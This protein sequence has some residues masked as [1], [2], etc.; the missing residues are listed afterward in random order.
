MTMRHLT[1]S[2]LLLNGQYVGG[3][4]DFAIA[5]AS[6]TE[7]GWDIERLSPSEP[8]VAALEPAPVHGVTIG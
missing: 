7:I 2:F 5:I 1:T 6:V 3:A 8:R 4:F